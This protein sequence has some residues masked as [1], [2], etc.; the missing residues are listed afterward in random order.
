VVKTTEVTGLLDETPVRLVIQEATVLSGM[1]RAIVAGRAQKEIE[2]LGL[3]AEAVSGLAALLVGR[4]T[5]PDLVGATV[6]AEGLDVEGLSL[7]DF[8]G[9]PQ[10][11]VDAWLAAV[12]DLC[13]HWY[14][15]RAPDTEEEVEAEKKGGTPSGSA[16]ES[17][18]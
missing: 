3:D 6:E 9:L 18:S 10:E 7:V 15:A 5:F 14:P 4:Y 17:G 1:R 8:L 12:Y 16:S 13:P 11:L 2:T